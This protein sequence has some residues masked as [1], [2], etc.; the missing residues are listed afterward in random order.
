MPEITVVISTF[1]RLR[2]LAAA[3][4]SALGQRDVDH[5]VIVVDNGSTDD[6]SSWLEGRR[7]HPRL[8][9]LRNEVSLGSIGGRNKGLAAAAGE[10]VGF[11][12]DDDL[13]APDK[14]RRQLDA[15]A[16]TG[17]HWVYAG[18]V[19]IDGDDRVRGGRPPPTPEEAMSALPFRY[20]LPGGI[21]NVVW[22]RGTLD[23]DGLLD[24]NLP[25]PADW[26][27]SL[28]LSRRG[29]PAMVRLPLVAY[30]QHGSNLSRRA[31][32]HRQEL[33]ILAR[34]HAD[35][36][37]GY[38]ID[39]AANRRFVA[40]EELRAGDRWAAFRNYAAAISAG[41]RR[42]VPRILGVVLP[43][44]GQR[45][46]QRRL[47]SDEAWLERAEGWLSARHPM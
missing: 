35:L 1:N 36:T 17:R 46:V 40:S 41:D 12:D 7:M 34:K 13:W 26:D 27:I 2:L 15:A 9:V 28:R 11:L 24:P 39:W 32:E 21:S 29:P 47:L 25:Q 44:S 16:A 37:D 30:R 8:R 4:D 3:L 6:T 20:S 23:G 19:H 42:S 43:E 10:W 45:W 22:R 33:A 38:P 14:L 31:A 5:E 18:C